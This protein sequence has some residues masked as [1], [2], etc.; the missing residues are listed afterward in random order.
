MKALKSLHP[1]AVIAGGLLIA[2]IGIDVFVQ[3]KDASFGVGVSTRVESESGLAFFI[4]GLIVGVLAGIGLFFTAIIMRERKQ[5]A[6]QKEL[7]LLLEEVSRDD[8]AFDM[9]EWMSSNNEMPEYQEDNTQSIDP[10]ERSADW[11]KS[12]EE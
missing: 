6:E 9:D 11:W 12:S 1:I 5:A 2:L 8:T 4:V 3:A 10:W 7:S